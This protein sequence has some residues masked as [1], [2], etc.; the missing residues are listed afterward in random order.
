M[1]T[2]LTED[3]IH[4]YD[5]KDQIMLLRD[6]EKGLIMKPIMSDLDTTFTKHRQIINICCYPL[7]I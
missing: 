2:T 7:Q 5:R 1:I 6:T 3:D 4:L